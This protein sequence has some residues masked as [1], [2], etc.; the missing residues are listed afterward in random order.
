MQQSNFDNFSNDWWKEDG[1]IRLLHSMNETRLLFIKE[2]I[3]S[4]YQ[5]FQSLEDIFHKK[6]ILDLG[7]GGG[8]LT[9]SLA[10][11]AKKGTLIP[12]YINT[13]AEENK[14]IK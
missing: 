10:K 12:E 4:R 2:R 5:S 3:Y 9:E 6:K 14:S 7:C 1:P 11:K 13:P 8:I